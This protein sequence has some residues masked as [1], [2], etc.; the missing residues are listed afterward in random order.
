MIVLIVYRR[1]CKNQL[2]T[3]PRQL[4]HLGYLLLDFGRM[5]EHETSSE[6][7][8]SLTSLDPELLLL[9]IERLDIRHKG[10]IA[11]VSTLSV[12]TPFALCSQ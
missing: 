5:D 3:Q 8:L 2:K 11:A 4:G 7:R 10:R 1:V 6:A 12:A 9:I